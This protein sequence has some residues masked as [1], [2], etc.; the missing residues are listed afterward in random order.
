MVALV[1]GAT[2]AAAE[3][4]VF[5]SR[6]SGDQVVPGPGDPDGFGVAWVRVDTVRGLVCYAVVTFN[7][8]FPA[9]VHI[10]RGGAGERGP[11]VLP[12]RDPDPNGRSV[13][14]ATNAAAAQAIAANPSGHYVNYHT[15]KFPSGALRSQVA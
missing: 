3:V 8:D 13:G 12:L 11:I 14:G 7:V 6:L 4:Y 1:G 2:P 9:V 10:H 15:F 5:S